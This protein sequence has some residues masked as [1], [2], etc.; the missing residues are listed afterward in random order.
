M[1]VSPRSDAVL[2]VSEF[3]GTAL[4]S[5]SLRS[6]VTYENGK[7]VIEKQYDTAGVL[8]SQAEYVYTDKDLLSE[9]TGRD[10]AGNGIWK[11]SYA[12]DDAGRFIIEVSFDGGGKKEWEKNVSYGASGFPEKEITYNADG[13]VNV[14]Q[15]SVYDTAGHLLEQKRL[16]PDD[17]LLKRTVY[18]YSS[19]GILLSEAHYDGNGLYE[20]V[21]YTYEEGLLKKVTTAG[22]DGTVKNFTL[23]T[24]NK[25][26]QLTVEELY[27]SD[28]I[29]KNR[30]EYAYDSRG[31]RIYQKDSTGQYILWEIAY[32]N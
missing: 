8:N 21:G 25:N 24:Y 31:S 18:T 14:K 3:R 30:T 20:T 1:A 6:A 2:S 27:G 9:I 11:Y 28:S 15:L 32:K 29:K 10:K 26:G 23:K 22:A 4:N 7:P 16:Y 5:L 19:D 12:Y 17:R 13:T